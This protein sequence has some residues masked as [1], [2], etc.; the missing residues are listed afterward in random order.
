GGH[1]DVGDPLAGRHVAV[2]TRHHAP[3]RETVRDRQRLAVHRDG[4]HR[5]PAVHRGRDRSAAGEAVERGAVQLVGAGLDARLAE[6][7]FQAGAQPLRVADVGPGDWVG[8]A[9]QRDVVLDW[10]TLDQVFETQG[11]LAADHAVD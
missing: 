1:L 11:Q 10:R 9:G 2:E 8:D 6:Q 4:K 7:G 3:D 5:V